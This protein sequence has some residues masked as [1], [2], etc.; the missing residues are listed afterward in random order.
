MRHLIIYLTD[1]LGRAAHKPSPK[2]AQQFNQKCA[3]YPR[4][5][6]AK[7]MGER[8]SYDYNP[9]LLRLDCHSP[10]EHLGNFG[11]SLALRDPRDTQ[12]PP[13]RTQKLSG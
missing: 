11:N 8:G 12:Y 2:S 7:Y 9:L 13:G 3:A 5:S 10:V 1:L 4:T 6:K